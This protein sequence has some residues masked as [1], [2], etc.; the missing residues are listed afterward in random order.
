MLQLVNQTPFVATLTLF[1]DERGVDTLYLV[2]CARFSIEPG[3]PLRL[4]DIQR[5]I[6]ERDEFYGDLRASSLRY[7]CELHLSKPATCVLLLGEA[8]AGGRPVDSLD[9]GLRIGPVDKTVRVT[10][11]RV[12]RADG[13]LSPPE[14]FTRMPLRYERARGGPDEPGNPVGLDPRDRVPNFADPGRPIE[15]PDARPPP[16]GFGPIAPTWA[17]RRDYVGTYDAAWRS[18][19]APY[20][21]HDFDARFFCTAP[22]DQILRTPLRGGELVELRNLWPVPHLRFQLPACG[23]TAEA[24]V[25]GR[26]EPLRPV[27]ETLLLEPGER[28][29]E[30]TWRGA[31]ACDKRLAQIERVTLTLARFSAGAAA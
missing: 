11:D 26:I 10:G 23:L 14:R 5:P 27:L 31:L 12:F 19:R 8:S 16:V 30:L 28:R 9:V 4:A 3:R 1:P 20:L 24:T 7:P 17:P 2:V 22:A 25:A 18:S 13:T 21:P 6:R 29:V 15:H